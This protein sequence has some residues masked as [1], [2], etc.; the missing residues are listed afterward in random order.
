M[1]N[2]NGVPRTAFQ[3]GVII[4]QLREGGRREG[5]VRP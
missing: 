1:P 3:C 2:S 4:A 5:T